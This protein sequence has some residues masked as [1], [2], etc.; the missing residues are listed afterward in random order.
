MALFTDLGD[1]QYDVIDLNT[2]SDLNRGPIDAAGYYIFGKIAVF[3][4]EITGFSAHGIDGFTAQQ[5]DLAVPWSGM[6]IPVDTVVL[7][8]HYLI[9]RALLHALLF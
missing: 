9:H 1:L 8:T 3:N 6:S 7:Y 4:L 5:R 2:A